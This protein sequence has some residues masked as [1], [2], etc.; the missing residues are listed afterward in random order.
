MFTGQ[1][2]P[3]TRI[4]VTQTIRRRDE[5]WHTSVT[6]QVMSSGAEKTGSWYTHSPQGKLMLPRVR[7]RK[8]DG[9]ITTLT[10][11]QNSRVEVL[12]TGSEA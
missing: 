6:G 10:L 8:D 7:V 3:G 9:E 2:K 12:A 1:L 5:D 4:R 11:D